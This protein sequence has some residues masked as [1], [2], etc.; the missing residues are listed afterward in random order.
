MS[1][2]SL[3]WNDPIAVSRWLAGLRL[4]WNDADAV[5]LDMLRPARARELGPA[6]HA[7]NYGA[8]RAQILQALAFADTPEPDPEPSDPAGCGGG[9]P[10]H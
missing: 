7:T 4:A 6:L 10:V 3:D 1:R 9:G 5:T 8:A 2:A